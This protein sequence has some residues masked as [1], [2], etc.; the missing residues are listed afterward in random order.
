MGATNTSADISVYG[1]AT[2]QTTALKLAGAMSVTGV[3]T[4]NVSGL[5]TLA[6]TSALT[7][8][9][10]LNL[11]AADMALSGSIA[12]RGQVTLAT[13]G[14]MTINAGA[15]LSTTSAADITL[16]AGGALI[17]RALV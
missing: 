5:A 17:N 10:G 14:A 7:S 11:T 6:A 16:N 3:T 2:L 1:A 13:T 15:T 4:A 8:N 9:G 12:Q